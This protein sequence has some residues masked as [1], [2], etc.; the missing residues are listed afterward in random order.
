MRPPR[1]GVRNGSA[2]VLALV[3]MAAAAL[4]LSVV[5]VQI[6]SHRAMLRQREHG[7]QAEWLA[8][9]GVELA[10]ARLLEKPAAFTEE[11]RDL[12]P[13]GKVRVVVEK[14]DPDMY[15]VTAEAEVGQQDRTPVVRTASARFRRTE[16]GGTVRLETLPVAE[17]T[18]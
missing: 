16:A 15:S 5:A 12:V 6:T 9:A 1:D 10:A 2:L 3:A 14:T 17:K 4:I 7:L 18:P 8:R 13:D 11:N